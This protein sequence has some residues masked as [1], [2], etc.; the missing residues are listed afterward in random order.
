M[1]RYTLIDGRH[2]LS[3]VASHDSLKLLVAV[4]SQ[5][6]PTLDAYF[7]AL[8]QFDEDMR[9]YVTS[10]LAV[11]DEHNVAPNFDRIHRALAEAGAKRPTPVFRIVDEATRAASLEPFKWG[12]ILF[13]VPK[14]RIIQI[15]NTY[16]EIRR[17][18]RVLT[19]SGGGSRR[20][21]S[22]RLP[23]TWQIVP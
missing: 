20:A 10:G 2:G 11:F 3:F 23:S 5:D 4:C 15:Q 14:K 21:R 13:N 6:P 18:G 17:E 1:M 7:D 9:E 19:H 22:Y 12:L 16:M 8:G